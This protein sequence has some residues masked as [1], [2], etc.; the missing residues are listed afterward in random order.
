MH[1]LPL[2][3]LNVS[4]PSALQCFCG[5]MLLAASAV[6]TALNILGAVGLGI[7]WVGL[8]VYFFTGMRAIAAALAA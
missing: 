4:T 5:L 7:A 2:L 1:S 6:S 8:V 3:L